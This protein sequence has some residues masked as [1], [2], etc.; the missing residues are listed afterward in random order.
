MGLSCLYNEIYSIRFPKAPLN[1]S[2]SAGE[3]TWWFM[4][5]Y[6]SAANQ[7]W[8]NEWVLLRGCS[9]VEH[10][11]ERWQ[12]LLIGSD[13]IS[14][15][16]VSLRTLSKALD[17]LWRVDLVCA[18]LMASVSLSQGDSHSIVDC[19]DNCVVESTR[20]AS[21]QSVRRNIWLCI[22]FFCCCYFEIS[23]TV[24]SKRGKNFHLRYC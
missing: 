17:T 23:F 8:H 20:R 9:E 3:T 15:F 22:V 14:H 12:C 11:L 1:S 7:D 6:I 5:S 4:I 13:N 10:A 24:R 18:T 16:S 2:G 21:L 19:V